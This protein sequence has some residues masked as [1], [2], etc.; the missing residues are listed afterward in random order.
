MVRPGRRISPITNDIAAN[1]FADQIFNL[2]LCKFPVSALFQS[3]IGG[4]TA[5]ERCI[6]RVTV[7]RP[8][9]QEQKP[10]WRVLRRATVSH[11][12]VAKIDQWCFVLLPL[13]RFRHVG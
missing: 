4:E 5:N 3:H 13:V 1:L 9:V 6:R 12:L 7:W 2:A 11:E 8:F 10:F